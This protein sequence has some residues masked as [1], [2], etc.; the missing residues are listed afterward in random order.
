MPQQTEKL[1]EVTEGGLV[2]ENTV[3]GTVT[4]YTVV[5]PTTPT[6]R[7]L[8][9]IDEI[10]DCGVIGKGSKSS[11]S[12]A[13]TI[14]SNPVLPK[15]IET[16]INNTNTDIYNNNICNVFPNPNN[17]LFNISFDSSLNIGSKIEI[18][19]SVGQ[20]VYSDVNY[21]NSY[22]V[23]YN[24]TIDLTS[25]SKGVYLINI[26]SNKNVYTNKIVVK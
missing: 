22:S 12:G 6:T 14:L 5:S 7:Y 8:V 21:D 19:N 26:V 16:S 9:G 17:G 4:Q 10:D 13:A 25:F 2:V 18:I 15:S 3:P 20:I 24:K 1:Y 11:K 23:S